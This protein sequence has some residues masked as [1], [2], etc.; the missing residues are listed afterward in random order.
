MYP[1]YDEW[2][3]RLDGWE[4]DTSPLTPTHCTTS[5]NALLS[6]LAAANTTLWKTTQANYLLQNAESVHQVNTLKRYWLC[7]VMLDNLMTQTE[8][9]AL[10]FHSPLFFTKNGCP[11]VHLALSCGW[12]LTSG[13]KTSTDDPMSFFATVP[14]LCSPIFTSFKP[15][16]AYLLGKTYQY[17]GTILHTVI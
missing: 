2:W 17:L 16:W 10:I 5:H 3:Q 8:N 9:V 11:M 7:C 4:A 15:L 1:G 14:P 12:P 13:L 6:H